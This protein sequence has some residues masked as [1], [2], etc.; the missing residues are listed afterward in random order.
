MCC[1]FYG[2]LHPSIFVIWHILIERIFNI[3]V[4]TEGNFLDMI[5]HY[6]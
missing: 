1:C 5:V 6:H 2:L 3:D 4:R